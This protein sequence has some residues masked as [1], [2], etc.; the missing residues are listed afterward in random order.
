MQERA[1]AATRQFANAI[2][3]FEG[4][5]KYLPLEHICLKDNLTQVIKLADSALAML[6]SIFEKLYNHVKRIF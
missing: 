3:V 5:G 2:N 1:I 4:L 6:Y